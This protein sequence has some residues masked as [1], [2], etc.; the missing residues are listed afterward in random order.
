[1]PLRAEIDETV[2]YAIQLALHYRE[3]RTGESS[4]LAA[5]RSGLRMAIIPLTLAAFIYNDRQFFG[6]SD[7]SDSRY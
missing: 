2:D 7:L 4:A 1:M 3:A 5:S 6:W